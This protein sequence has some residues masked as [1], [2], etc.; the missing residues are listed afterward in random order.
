MTPPVE[1][2][3]TLYVLDQL[4][5][6]ERAAFEARLA[7]ESE[8]RT[9]VHSLELT[10]E[11]RIRSL[12]QHTP[13]AHLLA[14]IE[15][16][17]D[18]R[19]AA[20]A[21]PAS[22]LPVWPAFTRWILPAAAAIALGAATFFYLDR[23]R[24]PAPPVVLVVALDPQRNTVTR[25]PLHDD[26]SGADG[27]F[28]QLASLAEQFWT[29]PE[30]LPR[31]ST[32]D[33]QSPAYALFDPATRQGFIAVQQ[34]PTQPDGKR[35]HLWL[36]DSETG[37]AL[38]AGSLPSATSRGLYFFSLDPATA[39]ASGPIHFLITA[40]D[41]STPPPARPRGTPILGQGPI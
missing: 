12:P 15:S 14:R 26:A 9:L 25:I 1:E 11:Q 22:L 38:D 3:A 21:P 20:A 2:L 31:A 29:R 39:P 5:P 10:L 6:A 17:L 37:R 28:V 23:Q 36:V 18:Q 19:P 24:A 33:G 40:E 30:N 41:P 7:R 16:Q 27:R 8:L 32:A 13:P 35:Y 34:L 4:E